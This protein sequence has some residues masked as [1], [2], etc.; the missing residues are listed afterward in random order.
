MNLLGVGEMLLGEEPLHWLG[1]LAKSALC[2]SVWR[3]LCVRWRLHVVVIKY[4]VPSPLPYTLGL[5]RDGVWD[6]LTHCVHLRRG[7]ELSSGFVSLPSMWRCVMYVFLC[8]VLI[9]FLS[10]GWY[11][12]CNNTWSLLTWHMQHRSQEPSCA[13]FIDFTCL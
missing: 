13:K 2:M 1:I 10:D 5:S 3:E 8:Y 7:S 12:S 9:L 6:N 4:W 11:S